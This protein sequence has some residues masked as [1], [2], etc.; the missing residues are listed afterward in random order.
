MIATGDRGQ[1][2]LTPFLLMVD[3]DHFKVLN[4]QHGHE[5]GDQA[6]I[7]IA[8]RLASV[9]REDD[10]LARWGGEEFMLLLPGT[11]ATAASRIAE[12]LRLVLANMPVDI[13]DGK[14]VPLTASI[15]IAFAASSDSLDALVRQADAALDAA[16]DGGRNRVW[17]QQEAQLA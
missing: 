5:A 15:G 12:R 2:N 10:V 13:G 11:G 17:Q 4:D 7:A 3:I 9:A 1:M 6:L 8:Q 16:K 14:A